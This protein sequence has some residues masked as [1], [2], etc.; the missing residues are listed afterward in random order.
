VE[1][2]NEN[3]FGEFFLKTTVA[4]F[5]GTFNEQTA[6]CAVQNA[7]LAASGEGALMK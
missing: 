4:G 5:C 1:I 7:A 2:R 3:F 6:T